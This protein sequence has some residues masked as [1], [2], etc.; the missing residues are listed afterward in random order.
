MLERTYTVGELH[1]ITG[2]PASTIYD[3]IRS[4]R[5]RAKPLPG[6]ERGYRVRESEA[7]RFFG[8]DGDHGE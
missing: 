8:L 7:E 4:G 2:V 3:A 1:R 6:N 5:L